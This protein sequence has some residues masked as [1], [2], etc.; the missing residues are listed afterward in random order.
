M[1]QVKLLRTN[2][3]SQLVQLSTVGPKQNLHLE[4][5]AS[6]DDVLLL[7]NVFCGH[8]YLQYPLYKNSPLTQE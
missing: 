7:G 4:S 1:L 8:T 2:P 5:H 3:V 6:Q